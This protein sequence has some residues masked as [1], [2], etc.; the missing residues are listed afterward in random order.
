M[1]TVYDDVVSICW[2][3]CFRGTT[4]GS[5][6]A[7]EI[8]L[9][10]VQIETFLGI[11][12]LLTTEETKLLRQLIAKNPQMRLYRDE[13][14]LFLLRLVGIRSMEN[15][16]SSRSNLSAEAIMRMVR[17][18]PSKRTIPEY[19][20]RS[21]R[22]TR[23]DSGQ[24]YGTG[25]TGVNGHSIDTRPER[26]GS[27]LEASDLK[28]TK[29]I[30]DSTW[31]QKVKDTTISYF[32]SKFRDSASY[33]VDKEPQAEI[34]IKRELEP[35]RSSSPDTAFLEEKIRRLERQCRQYETELEQSKDS[36]SK[37]RLQEVLEAAKKQDN[38]IDRLEKR[39]RLSRSSEDY[40]FG[41]LMSLAFSRLDPRIVGFCNALLNL[42]LFFFIAVVFLNILRLVFFTVIY[43]LQ[44]R[45]SNLYV[46][47]GYDD[48]VSVSM[49]WVLEM[50]W[51]EYKIY[52]IQ[53]WIGY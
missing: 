47:E 44:N 33:K 13:A 18:H 3:N 11:S 34:R 35:F 19:I 26:Y 52:Q 9:F 7:S 23:V 6:A 37:Q 16:I 5:L 32:P 38:L 30:E 12:N 21:V 17:S 43:I 51:L 41:G 8:G 24:S 48:E 40:S 20:D 25:Y 49:S 28:S 27:H 22:E 42:T 2:S 1:S 53:E 45:T 39:S 10:I 14:A 4:S 36:V 31:F 46:D 15:L 29:P 50:P